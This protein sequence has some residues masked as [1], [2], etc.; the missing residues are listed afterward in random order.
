MRARRTLIALAVA[1]VTTISIPSHAAQA[2]EDYAFPLSIAAVAEVGEA[3]W[4]FTPD[5]KPNRIKIVDDLTVDIGWF[6]CQ[7]DGDGICGQGNDVTQSG[8]A[9]GGFQ[10]IA[11]FQRNVE[12]S[13]YVDLFNINCSEFATTGR[14]TLSD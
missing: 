14:I 11:G 10:D 12:T 6:V 1:L 7:D 9:T 5:F 3:T 13:V 8:C 2:G 4:V